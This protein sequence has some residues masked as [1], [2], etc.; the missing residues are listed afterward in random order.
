MI[1]LATLIA[2]LAL[3]LGV[4]A[5]LMRPSQ[6]AIDARL[7]QEVEAFVSDSNE[8][9]VI[10]LLCSGKAKTACADLLFLNRR[11]RQRTF[12]SEASIDVG[13]R[14]LECLGLLGFYS[15]YRTVGGKTRAQ[16]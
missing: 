5:H 9:G 7:R 4:A 11:F 13:E 6:S 2:G 1:R 14:G 8:V 15:C 12:H 10:S 16:I 3:V